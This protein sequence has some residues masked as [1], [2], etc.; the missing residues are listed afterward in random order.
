MEKP[1]TYL[2]LTYNWGQHSGKKKKKQTKETRDSQSFNGS[3]QFH[4]LF[5]NVH[6]VY[7]TLDIRFC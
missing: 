5:E 7:R 1:L 6:K 3:M 4:S 2:V